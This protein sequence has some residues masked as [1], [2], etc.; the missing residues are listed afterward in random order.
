MQEYLFLRDKIS[1]VVGGDIKWAEDVLKE[2]MIQEVNADAKEGINIFVAPDDTR[3]KFTNFPHVE[4][5]KYQKYKPSSVVI[6]MYPGEVYKPTITMAA[7]DNYVWG[8]L[9]PELPVVI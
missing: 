6:D 9:E 5:S 3:M 4:V 1:K 8:D 7:L 2:A